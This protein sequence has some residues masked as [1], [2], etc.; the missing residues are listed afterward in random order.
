MS[1]SDVAVADMQWAFPL[2]WTMAGVVVAVAI[3]LLAT[4]VGIAAQ[5]PSCTRVKASLPQP[6]TDNKP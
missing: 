2:L 1:I 4:L 3:L 5:F 6:H